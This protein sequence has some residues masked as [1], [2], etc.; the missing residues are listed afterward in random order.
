MQASHD[1]VVCMDYLKDRL[2]G[3][4]ASAFQGP[5]DSNLKIT[6]RA[7]SPVFRSG[8]WSVDL[9]TSNICI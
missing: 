3:A 1:L 2:I 4:L 7:I 6:T 9:V 5:S 8:N